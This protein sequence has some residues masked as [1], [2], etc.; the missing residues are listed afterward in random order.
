MHLWWLAQDAATKLSAGQKANRVSVGIA[1]LA[2]M[3]VLLIVLVVWVMLT[4]AARS[5]RR[6]LELEKK[7]PESP[8]PELKDP[9]VEAGKRVATPSS[10][11]LERG[12]RA[13]VAQPAGG[14]AGPTGRPVALVTGAARRVGRAIAK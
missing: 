1:V 13:T 12:A 4:N 9:W 14:G 8:A 11:E 2:A 10:A 3:V 5:R 6:D 7:K